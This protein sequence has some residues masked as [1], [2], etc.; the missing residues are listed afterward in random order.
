MGLMQSI[1]GPDKINQMG[2]MQ[3]IN[4]LYAIN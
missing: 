3:S 1:N 4:W 2:L